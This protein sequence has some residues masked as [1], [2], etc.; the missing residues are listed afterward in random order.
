M[1]S[2]LALVLAVVSIGIGPG[3]PAS[4]QA[5]PADVGGSWKLVLMP[6]SDLEIA[7][8]D[9]KPADGKVVATVSGVN[10][11][12]IGPVD[13]IGASVRGNRVA[14]RLLGQGR[15]VTFLGTLEPDG[16][17]ARGIIKGPGGVYRARVERTQAKA[18]AAPNSEIPPYVRELGSTQ[19]IANL[20]SR[21]A[22]VLELVAAH[23]GDPVNPVAHGQVVMM[24]EVA[25]LSA[26]EVV[27]VVGRWLDE[28]R[29]FGPEWVGET[30]AQVLRALQ[31]KIAY[32]ALATEVGQAAEKSL[33]GDASI[34]QRSTL[35]NLLAQSA[36]LAGNE[37]VAAEAAG[38]AREYD[39]KIDD[40]YLARVPPFKAQ[41]YAGRPGGQGSRVVLMEIFTGAECPPCVGP[42]V[43]FDAL[44]RTYK[45][46]EFIGLQYHLHV[47]GPD[48]LT[49]TDT[50]G[51]AENYYRQEVLS[52]PTVFFNGGKFGSSG[53]FLAEAQDRYLEF[54][55]VIDPD[56]TER[57]LADLVLTASRDGDEVR[58]SATAKVSPGTRRARLK[59][60][61]ALIEKMVRYPGGNKL[62]L[63]H[64]VVRAFPGGLDGKSVADGETTW[65]AT[66]KLGELRK[67]LEASLKSYAETSGRGFPNPLPPIDLDD[68]AVVAMIQNDVDHAIWHAAQVDVDAPR[69]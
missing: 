44:L 3:S 57:K 45:P 37:A 47:P 27:K 11:R 32:A 15:S 41:P 63:H 16:Q 46:T 62:R 1:R 65:Q 23:P 26:D 56:L 18:L 59:L 12:L 40:A 68:L 20:K 53:G 6:A 31:G 29:P 9:L 22:K 10:E 48:P 36:A 38:R 21:V 17:R 67:S 64:N 52:T 25:G 43:A 7:I 33:P 49:N 58:V 35:A 30:Q 2:A 5:E 24:A 55:R 28:A 61:L 66:V 42:D 60:R 54:R 39:A 19:S 4:S 8:F 13:A 51:R 34:D 14:I 69:H 50:V